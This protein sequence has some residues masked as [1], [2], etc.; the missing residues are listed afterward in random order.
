MP[1]PAHENP[2]HTA[3]RQFVLHL[4]LE[5]G[6]A[7]NTC[8]AYENDVRLFGAFLARHGINAWH[9]VTPAHIT[10]FLTERHAL[11]RSVNTVLRELIALRVFF[12]YLVQERTVQED[13][14]ARVEAPK[15]WRLLPEVL[16]EGEMQQ[17]LTA[18]DERT[19][20]G[21]RDKAM[22]E[23]LYATGLRVSELVTLRLGDV[24]LESGFLRCRGK[25]GKERVVPIGAPA[26]AALRAYLSWRGSGAGAEPLFC[27]SR[28]TAMTRVNFWKRI[29]QYAKR[30]GI[31][32]AAHP[33][34]VRHSFATHLLMHGADLRV[35][36]ELLGH[37]NI[38]TTQRYT[39]VDHQ[40]LRA[41]HRQFHP[42][43]RLPRGEV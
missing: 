43:A 31:L 42:R 27:T 24:D 19:W 6:L 38:T 36:Q 39:H 32:K 35:V 1:T 30:A 25:G 20:R 5:R 15:V 16:S 29:T 34:I 26:R 18:P 28:H 2:L 21:A 40:R 8:L 17:L 12:R 22:L 37:A 4:Q 3:V 23:L 11:R 7:R 9:E 33:H 14:T 10:D 13:V 41:V